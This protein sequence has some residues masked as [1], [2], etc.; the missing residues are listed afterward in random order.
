MPQESRGWREVVRRLVEPRHRPRDGFRS[1]ACIPAPA[2]RRGNALARP[3]ARMRRSP[4]P[5]GLSPSRRD[6][7]PPAATEPA[8]PTQPLAGGL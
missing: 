8:D 3:R 6:A 5:G 1:T 2:A 7:A 4:T